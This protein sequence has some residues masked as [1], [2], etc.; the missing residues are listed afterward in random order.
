M[1]TRGQI[2]KCLFAMIF[3]AISPMFALHLGCVSQQIIVFVI[4]DI[5]GMNA[6]GWSVLGI[7]PMSLPYAQ[8]EETAPF[9]I[10]ADVKR[11]TLVICVNII[12][13]SIFRLMRIVQCA[14]DTALAPT[15]MFANASKDT[16]E[17]N[18]SLTYVSIFYQT[19]APFVL[20]MGLVM[21]LTHVYA[22]NRTMDRNAN[23]HTALEC[24]RMSQQCV[25]HTE[26]AAHQTSVHAKKGS[27]EE[28]IVSIRYASTCW[29][30]RQMCALHMDFVSVSIH[31]IAS[32]D[33]FIQ[34]VRLQCA[35]ELWATQPLL[36]IHT[37]VV[38]LQMIASV[39]RAMLEKSA[40]F[41]CA[42]ASME[43]IPWPARRGDLASLR[44]HVSV[45]IITLVQNAM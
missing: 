42:M 2:A 40:Q 17:K 25:R 35:L 31:A 45:I 11:D 10:N 14:V 41:Q 22:M 38:L 4:W 7:Y 21:L 15:W 43:R 33:S 1:V 29:R 18:A 3:W 8:R 37:E 19:K 39:R 28:R 26:S 23:F 6:N 16:V 12:S 32:M 36:V 9:R 27:L 34:S 44:T 5:T 20:R 24:S 13:V 30:T